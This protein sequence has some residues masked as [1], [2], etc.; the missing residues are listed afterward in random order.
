MCF[1]CISEQTAIFVQYRAITYRFLQ[2]RQYFLRGTNWVLKLDRY[3]FV[4]EG[5]NKSDFMETRH[6]LLSYVSRK[7]GV[8]NG[9]T[10][11][12][13]SLSPSRNP[14]GGSF[15]IGP[16]GKLGKCLETDMCFYD[17]CNVWRRSGFKWQN[18]ICNKRKSN[19]WSKSPNYPTF[20]YPT[21]R[22]TRHSH[23][24]R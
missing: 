16:D 4:L 23:T 21:F 5:L 12:W 1:A 17:C 22:F 19:Q 18:R 15:D 20:G 14:V 10:Q 13:K 7:V 6:N 3:S 9:Y 24:T 2:P 11:Q 8:Y